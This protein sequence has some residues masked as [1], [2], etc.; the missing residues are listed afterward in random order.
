MREWFFG[1]RME[2]LVENG[3]K[4]GKTGVFESEEKGAAEV[5]KKWVVL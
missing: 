3:K 2:V 4:R 1:G 5:P